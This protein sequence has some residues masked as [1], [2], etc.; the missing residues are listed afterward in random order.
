MDSAPSP[1]A[2]SPIKIR[3]HSNQNIGPRTS[4]SRST[5]GYESHSDSED[6]D[7]EDAGATSL[8]CLPAAMDSAPSPKATSNESQESLQSKNGPL[9]VFHP[10]VP[11]PICSNPSKLKISF[12]SVKLQYDEVQFLFFFENMNIK[13]D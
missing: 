3:N 1:K 2:T 7:A 12:D 5:R 4:K 10:R 13:G 9:D 6:I 8:C 11:Y